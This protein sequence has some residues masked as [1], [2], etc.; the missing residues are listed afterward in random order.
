MFETWMTESSVMAGQLPALRDEN[1]LSGFAWQFPRRAAIQTCLLMAV[2]PDPVLTPANRREK[3]A[4]ASI[5]A[6]AK[7]F[8][9]AYTRMAAY[10]GTSAPVMECVATEWVHPEI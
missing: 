6:M 3:K 9:S 7:V 2:A 8:Q 10:G 5:M 1:P 4:E